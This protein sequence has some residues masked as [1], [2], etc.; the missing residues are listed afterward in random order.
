MPIRWAAGAMGSRV[1]FRM[2][3]PVVQRARSA[4]VVR[5]PVVRRARRAQRDRMLR[6]IP[7]NARCAGVIACWCGAVMP[8]RHTSVGG[9]PAQPA[10]P[11]DRCAPEIVAF[12]AVCAALAAAERQ[13][14]GRMSR[15]VISSQ[16][17]MGKFVS[18]ISYTQ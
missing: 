15:R 5:W 10:V 1:P 9:Q 8:L 6:V 2:R 16:K 12:L 18:M 17:P 3:T 11:A 7:P 14:V 4:G 13:P